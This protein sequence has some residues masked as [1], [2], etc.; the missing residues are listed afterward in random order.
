MHIRLNVVA[1]TLDDIPYMEKFRWGNFWQTI[2]KK[3]IARKNLVNIAKSINMPNRMLPFL[4]VWI[5][6]IF[7][8]S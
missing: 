1:D 2:K 5:R 6:K 7:M 8:N 4:L 3:L